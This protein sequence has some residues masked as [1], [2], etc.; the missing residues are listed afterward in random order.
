MMRLEKSRISTWAMVT[1][2]LA[3]VLACKQNPSTVYVDNSRMMAESRIFIQVRDSMKLYEKSWQ[4]DAETLKDSV[5]AYMSFIEKGGG[6]RNPKDQEAQKAEFR[7]R[8]EVLAQFVAA[9]KRKGEDLERN[10]MEPALR[11]VNGFLQEYCEQQGYDF[12]LGTTV[13]GSI[14]AANRKMDISEAFIKA[15]N[16]SLK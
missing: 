3:C 11:R 8:Q 7:R 2:A 13:G 1:L 4:Q 15:M 10:L 16:E 14:L 5:E 12:I 6:G 9:K